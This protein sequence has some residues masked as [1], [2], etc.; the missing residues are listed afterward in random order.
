M[1]GGVLGFEPYR[2]PMRWIRQACPTTVTSDSILATTCAC[3]ASWMEQHPKTGHAQ[4][5]FINAKTLS[6]RWW[7]S[8]W[9]DAILTNILWP[10]TFSAYWILYRILNKHCYLSKWFL[11]IS[12]QTISTR[13]FFWRVYAYMYQT[14]FHGAQETAANWKR[15]L[16]KSLYMKTKVCTLQRSAQKHKILVLGSNTHVQNRTHNLRRTDQDIWKVNHNKNCRYLKALEKNIFVY[17]LT[18]T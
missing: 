2:A 14:S 15:R 13:F 10:W 6:G 16:W 5:V 3:A 12:C 17:I 4:F 11:F 18:Y 8:W 1:T 7:R 9:T